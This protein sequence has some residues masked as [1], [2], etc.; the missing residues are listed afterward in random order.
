MANSIQI[1]ILG[2]PKAQ[3]R[4]RACN[5]GRYI[6]I[7]DPS[8]KE[9]RNLLKIIQDKA[10]EKP[11]TNPLALTIYYFMSRPKGHYGTGKNAGKLKDNAPVQHSKKPDLDNLIKLTIDAMNKVFFYDDSQ[12]Y[13]LTTSKVYDE[14][15]RTEILIEE[16]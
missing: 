8:S 2:D 3:K 12:I 9:K 4:A 1:T 11:F 13:K 10:P 5:V 14:K 15:P 16:L 6:N 7:Y